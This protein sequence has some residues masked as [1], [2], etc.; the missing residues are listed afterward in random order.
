[1]FFVSLYASLRGIFGVK[2]NFIVTPKESENVTFGEA[3]A[4]NWRE[5]TFAV[6][7]VGVAVA[8]TRSPLPVILIAVPSVLSVYLT[9]MTS[10][11]AFR[12]PQREELS[13]IISWDELVSEQLAA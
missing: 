10:T 7:L 2:A 9:L 5:I 8:T 12:R 13:H 4:H 1:M 6:A 11:R 3:L